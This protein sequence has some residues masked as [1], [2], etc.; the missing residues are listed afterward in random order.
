MSLDPYALRKLYPAFQRTVDGRPAVYLDGPGGTQVPEPVIEAMDGTLRRG[1]SNLGGGFAS[2]RDAADITAAARSAGAD[3]FGAADQQSIIF[4]QNMTSLTLAMSRSLAR[5]WR[6]GD[7]IVTT[8]L[9]HDANITPWRLAATER[10]ATVDVW[11]F[12]VDTTRLELSDLEALLTERTKLVAVTYASNAFG[13]VSDIGAVVAAAH[14]VGAMVYVDAVHYAPHGLIDVAATDP[15]FLVASA[16][17]F[18]GPHTGMLYGRRSHLE[19]LTAYKVRPAPGEGAEKWETGTQSFESLSA[20]TAA[21]DYLASIG[22]GE[23]RRERIVSAYASIKRHEEWAGGRFLAGLATMPHLRL[24][25]LA[26][27]VGRVPTFALDV[28]GRPPAEVADEL[29]RRGVFVWSG[30][31]YALEAMER[32]GLNDRGGLVRIGIVH[33]TTAEEVDRVLEELSLLR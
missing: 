6:P 21:V 1:I 22:T 16:Y 7:R 2:S 15:D 10:G 3:L 12:D 11:E 30:D 23:T 25:G 18:F 4:G 33:T 19:R 20:V 5:E 13:T 29:G 17:K 14:A 28:A 26:N 24:Y 9:D 27:M 32:L 8:R 31:Y